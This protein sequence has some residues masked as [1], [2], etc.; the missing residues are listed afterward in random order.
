MD[1]VLLLMK[2]NILET[3]KAVADFWKIDPSY[4]WKLLKSSDDEDKP[5]E[6]DVQEEAQEGEAPPEE[7]QEAPP[8]SRFN[9][10][11]DQVDEI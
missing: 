10:S 3:F 4:A 6:E 5:P 8:A 1:A 11:P 9:I 7:A 2:H